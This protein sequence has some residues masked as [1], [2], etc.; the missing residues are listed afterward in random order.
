MI[1]GNDDK[2]ADC[3]RGGVCV[4]FWTEALGLPAGTVG[5]GEDGVGVGGVISMRGADKRIAMCTSP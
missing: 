5:V 1:F 3:G 4:L 2:S